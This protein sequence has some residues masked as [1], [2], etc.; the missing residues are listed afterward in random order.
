MVWEAISFKRVLS[1]VVMERTL[2][3]RYYGDVLE[4]G[5]LSKAKTTL[6]DIWAVVQNNASIHSAVYT[7]D[8]L[9]ANYVHTL[10]WPAKSPE[11]NIIKNVCKL[12][13]RKDYAHGQKFEKMEGLANAI[14]DCWKITDHSYIKSLCKSIPRNLILVITK[15]G[16][17][18]LLVVLFVAIYRL[19]RF[20]FAFQFA[21][22]STNVRIVYSGHV[23]LLLVCDKYCDLPVFVSNNRIVF[24]QCIL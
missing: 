2:N 19:L 16:N 5:L 17:D 10:D 18:G 4:Q 13:P 12:L 11:L 21:F 9:A 22:S 20:N 14:R 23:M 6:R 15:R 24:L 1:L 8:W 7:L 3:A